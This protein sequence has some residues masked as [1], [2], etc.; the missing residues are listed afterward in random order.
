MDVVLDCRIVF[1][2]RYDLRGH[3]GAESV[4]PYCHGSVLARGIFSSEGGRMNYYWIVDS[5]TGCTW[6]MGGAFRDKQSA[7]REML[8]LA[9]KYQNSDLRVVQRQLKEAEEGR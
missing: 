8:R 7:T 6:A 4:I 3:C 5:V 9:W 1:P 2:A